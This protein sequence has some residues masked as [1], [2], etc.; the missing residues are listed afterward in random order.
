MPFVSIA[1]MEIAKGKDTLD[2]DIRLQEID[3]LITASPWT[4]DMDSYDI[5]EKS[6]AN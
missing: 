5:V 4:M 1:R 3:R 2:I 6:I